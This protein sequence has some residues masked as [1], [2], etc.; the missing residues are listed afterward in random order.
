MEMRTKIVAKEYSEKFDLVLTVPELT[1]EEAT[2][3]ATLVELELDT[4]SKP[5][6]KRPVRKA[7]PCT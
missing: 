3:I 4:L 1:M 2:R 6:A 5:K 7:K